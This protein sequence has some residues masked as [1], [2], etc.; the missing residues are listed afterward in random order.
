LKLNKHFYGSFLLSVVILSAALISVTTDVRR[1]EGKSSSQPA[2]VDHPNALNI[3]QPTVPTKHELFS[4]D[5]GLDVIAIEQVW[6]AYS[7]YT[8]TDNG[9][10]MASIFTPD[11]V[12][13]H[14]WNDGHGKFLP[15]FGI[16]APGDVGKNMTPEGP[17]GSGCILSGRDQIA[18]YKRMGRVEPLAW[19]GHFHHE[20]PS[21]LVKVSDDGQTAVLTVPSVQVGV[22]DKGQGHISTNGYR[23]FFKKTPEGWEMAELYDILDHPSVTQ[24]CDVNGNLPREFTPR[25]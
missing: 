8:D 6:A 5:H 2:W 25:R 1:V 13:Q 21:I 24:A 17:I 16:V 7:F 18:Q 22:D 9:P 3:Q 10:G 20:T 14:L 11:G 12:F 23:A 4:E 15:D 19:P